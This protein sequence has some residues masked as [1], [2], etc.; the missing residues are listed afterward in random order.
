MGTSEAPDFHSGALLNESV[1][2]AR[3]EARERASPPITPLKRD[4]VMRLKQSLDVDEP[5]YFVLAWTTLLLGRP[6]P[7]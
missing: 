7:G 5:A 1:S 6:T 2:A 3:L 4:Y